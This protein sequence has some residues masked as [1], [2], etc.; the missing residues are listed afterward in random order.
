MV[1]ANGA[2]TS[3]VALS[4][5]TSSERLA[6]LDRRARLDQPADQLGLVDAFADFGQCEVHDVLS[7]K[8]SHHE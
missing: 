8:T 1:P 5:M 7:T 3:I 2:G 4:V 6:A